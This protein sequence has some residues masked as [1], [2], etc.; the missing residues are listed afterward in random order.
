MITIKFPKSPRTAPRKKVQSMGEKYNYSEDDYY[1]IIKI[2]K[3]NN[4]LYEIFEIISYWK[5]SCCKI[6]EEEIETSSL[7]NILDCI[8][9]KIPSTSLKWYNLNKYSFMDEKITDIKDTIGE[10]TNPN[11]TIYFEPKHKVRR[12]QERDIIT[13]V[14][15]MKEYKVEKDKLK[16]KVIKKINL[17]KKIYPE[18]NGDEFLSILKSF[19]D[20]II[21]VGK[22]E[23]GLSSKDTLNI[24][25]YM[26]IIELLRK[27]EEN[28][29]K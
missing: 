27:I 3:I 10:I 12:L 19:P 2:P 7:K 13:V 9:E 20:K 26:E 11:E 8:K 24:E 6:D 25:G 14:K 16:E 22:N 15:Y 1:S 28:T 5:N 23:D 4:D 17:I 18:F 21:I 29:R